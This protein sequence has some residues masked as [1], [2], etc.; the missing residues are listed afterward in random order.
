MTLTQGIFGHLKKVAENRCRPRNF[1]SKKR[2]GLKNDTTFLRRYYFQSSIL[3]KTPSCFHLF[4][5]KERRA[6]LTL[7][8]KT[9]LKDI[10]KVHQ[11]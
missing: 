9:L 8:H 5:S 1:R 4:Q 10:L 6:E 3:F 11:S 2:A 7:D